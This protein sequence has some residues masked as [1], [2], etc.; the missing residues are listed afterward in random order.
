[1]IRGYPNPTLMKSPSQGCL[2]L[3]IKQEAYDKDIFMNLRRI[4]DKN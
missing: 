4:Y 3:C 1:M 2:T